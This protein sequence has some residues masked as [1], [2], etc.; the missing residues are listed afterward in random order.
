[1]E[2]KQLYLKAVKINTSIWLCQSQGEK[3]PQERKECH[4]TGWGAQPGRRGLTGAPESL[5]TDTNKGLFCI[6]NSHFNYPNLK[7]WGKISFWVQ[8]WAILRQF[9]FLFPHIQYNQSDCTTRQAPLSIKA[10]LPTSTG[11]SQTTVTAAV[12]QTWQWIMQKMK[13]GVTWSIIL[14]SK[15]SR[16]IIKALM[17]T[18][19]A[20][21]HWVSFLGQR[22]SPLLC[23]NVNDLIT[24]LPSPAGCHQDFS[25]D[26]TWT[27]WAVN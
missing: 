6:T 16:M 22:S 27:L 8:V 5:K 12:L 26:G 13:T 20:G 15:R 7:L 4:Q 14:Q 17:T 11:A 3:G 25:L 21:H 10:G 19:G 18:L 9:L 1:M 2:R 24:V 23:R